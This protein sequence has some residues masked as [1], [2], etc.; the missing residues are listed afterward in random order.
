MKPLSEEGGFFVETY[1]ARENIAHEHLPDR[2]SDARAHGTS[3]LYLLTPDSFS[4]MHRLKSDETFHFYLGDPVEMLR[5]YPD[6]A[7]DIVTMGHDIMAG[8]MVQVT[9]ARDIWQGSRL[10]PGGGFALMGC[11]VAPGFD[12]AD[13][14]NGGREALIS[15]YPD[16]AEMIWRL[17]K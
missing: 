13:Y 10:M 6:S 4:A 7:S 12:F 16:R 2:Y 8:Q 14:E 1:R 11:T 15:Q 17:A 5:L 9:V 3:I